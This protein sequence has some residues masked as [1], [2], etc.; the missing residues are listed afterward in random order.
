MFIPIVY[1]RMSV[2]RWLPPETCGEEEM[3]SR[4]GRIKCVPF[5]SVWQLA[6]GALSLIWKYAPLALSQPVSLFVCGG[7][8]EHHDGDD[9][10]SL[11]FR[12]CYYYNCYS[13]EFPGCL[14]YAAQHYTHFHTHT[15]G[16]QI[17]LWWMCVRDM[18]HPRCLPLMRQG[19]VSAL[20][21]LCIHGTQ[22]GCR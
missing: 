9:L 20:F 8:S 22:M 13:L 17:V 2:V 15:Q 7:G 18:V 21:S 3:K 4:R 19:G 1:I 11:S 10:L 14:N 5:F 6:T 16:G 12:G